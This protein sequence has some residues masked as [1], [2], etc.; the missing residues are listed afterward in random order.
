MHARDPPGQ[1]KVGLDAFERGL[2]GSGDEDRVRAAVTGA[3]LRRQWMTGAG[4]GLARER[5][6]DVV[7]LERVQ[8]GDAVERARGRS[9]QLGPYTVPGETGNGLDGHA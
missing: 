2:A 3:R 8:P 6:M 7:Q 4:D 5:K 1:R 9:H